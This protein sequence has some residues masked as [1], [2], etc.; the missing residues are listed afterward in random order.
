LFGCIILSPV[1]ALGT[2][3]EIR[4]G[5]MR[6]YL[7]CDRGV[8]L[9][10]YKAQPLNSSW[11]AHTGYLCMGRTENKTTHSASRYRLYK[12]QMQL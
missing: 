5:S 4:Y 7:S 2:D 9:Q 6:V 12:Q 1:E 8:G 10:G 11:V 3:S